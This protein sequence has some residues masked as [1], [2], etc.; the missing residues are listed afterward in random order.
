M[1]YGPPI[2]MMPSNRLEVAPALPQLQSYYR[3]APTKAN[4]Y[5]PNYMELL[6]QKYGE[7]RQEDG[8]P[9]HEDPVAN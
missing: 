5:R 8:R 2:P 4:M 6:S 7:E 9:M 1:A 3:S